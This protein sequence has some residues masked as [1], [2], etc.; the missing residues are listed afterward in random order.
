MGAGTGT[1][2][3]NLGGTIGGNMAGTP[4]V[5]GPPASVFPTG[6][7]QP[8]SGVTQT[9]QPVDPNDPFAELFG[10]GG[11]ASVPNIDLGTMPTMSGGWAPGFEDAYNQ[12]TQNMQNAVKNIYGGMQ[13][14]NAQ[15]AQID[16]G[17]LSELKPQQVQQSQALQQ[18]LSGQG[19]STD[20]MKRLNAGSTDA[21][22]K[23]AIANR[24]SARLQAE[25]S[26]LGGSPV[27]QAMESQIARQRGDSATRALNENA[28]QNA[29]VGMENFRQGANMDFSREQN[30]MQQ[31]N[32]MALAKASQMLT[33]MSQNA[34]NQQQANMANF[35]AGVNKEMTSA[36]A[37]AGIA[38]G[39]GAKFGDASINKQTDADKMNAG[40]AFNWA[41]NQAGLNQ[42]TNNTNANL[43]NSQWTTGVNGLLGLG[44][45]NGGA[46]YSA[47][48]NNLAGQQQPSNLLGSTLQN[49]GQGMAGA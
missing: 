47:Q 36:G 46:N 37:Q 27:Q 19:Y 8:G 17:Q 41:I 28:I 6:T 32:A 12:N 45:G 49:A 44:S 25:Q 5:G 21:I 3:G 42:N 35:G 29:N 10:L 26:G 24:G 33:A 14:P 11:L 48:A 15:A 4:G 40:N 1:G 39:Q 2:F 43:K 30:N 7:N 16:T 20:V 38:G 9:N 31:A 13:L 22:N 23:Q 34:G 18:L